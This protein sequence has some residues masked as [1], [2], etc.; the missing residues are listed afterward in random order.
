MK[1]I[2]LHSEVVD[3]IQLKRQLIIVDP[4]TKKETIGYQS[5]WIVQGSCG[6]CQ[7]L[8]DSVFMKRYIEYK[9][10]NMVVAQLKEFP[11]CEC[12]DFHVKPGE[13]VSLCESCGGAVKFNPNGL[14]FRR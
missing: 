8:A 10:P 12:H 14:T 13:A 9:N 5:E 6:H 4:D 7:I 11:R 3:A 2:P 1:Y